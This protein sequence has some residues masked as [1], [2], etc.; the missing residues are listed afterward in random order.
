M[1][2][3]DLQLAFPIHEILGIEPGQGFTMT[4]LQETHTAVIF[5]AVLDHDPDRGFFVKTTRP[6]EGQ[7]GGKSLGL[8]EVQFYQFIGSFSPSL[9]GNLPRCFRSGIG[10]DGLC[11]YLVLEDLEKDYFAHDAVDFAVKDNWLMALTALATFH[12]NLT[13]KLASS[14][15]AVHADGLYDLDRYIGKLQDAFMRFRKNNCEVV[16]EAVL[17][18]LE[19]SIPV[20]YAIERENR[21]RV[22]ANQM[23]TV[24]HRDA[25]IRNFLYPRM[26]GNAAKI[27]DWQFWGLGIGTYDL[28][29]L[30]GSSLKPEMRGEQFSLVRH[31]FDIYTAN[32]QIE[33]AWE[34]CWDDYRK[35]II[36]NL[37]MPVWQFAGFGWSHQE[38][39]GTLQ[40]A[41]ENYYALGCDKMQIV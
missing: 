2:I 31:Y 14:Q 19:Q 5:K 40:A 18:L 32:S 17:A 3:D 13:G 10:E 26:Q 36:D 28:R 12:R 37:F 7:K 1:E 22:Q 11:Y 23:T 15:V 9:T 33:Y 21:K 27:V 38:W 25:H 24:L 30:L 34:D 4:D 39:G 20:L 16:D 8:R 29:H 35:G 6:S 41:V